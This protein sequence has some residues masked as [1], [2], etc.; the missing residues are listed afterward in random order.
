MP[1]LGLKRLCRI[2]KGQYQADRRKTPKNEKAQKRQ[3]K[4]RAAVA[5]FLQDAAASSLRIHP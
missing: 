4:A 2:A 3:E 5:L 1:L